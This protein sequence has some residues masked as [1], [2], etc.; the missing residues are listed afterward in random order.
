M[1]A[2]NRGDVDGWLEPVHPEIE[3]TSAIAAQMQGAETVYRGTEEARWFWDEWHSIWDLTVELSEIR[4]LGDTVVAIGRM[5]LRGKAS[6]VDLEDQPV[7]YVGEFDGGLLR[8][9]RSYRDP[10][11][12]LRDAGAT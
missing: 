10:A 11:E 6:G 1:E 5:H 9:M 4:D 2:W 12:A 7:A 3:W 8:R